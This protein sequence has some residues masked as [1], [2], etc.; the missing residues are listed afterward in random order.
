VLAL[1]RGLPFAGEDYAWADAEGITSTL[2]WLVTRVVD[3]AAQLAK[4]LKDDAALLAAATAGL[5]MMPGD[6]HFSQLRD[7][8]AVSIS[9]R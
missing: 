8:V 6:E 2:V 3:T 7:A 9:M 5:R 4:H 1:V